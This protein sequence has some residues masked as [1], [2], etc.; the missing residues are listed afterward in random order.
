MS[1]PAPQQ[2]DHTAFAEE[3]AVTAVYRWSLHFTTQIGYR[4]LWMQDLALA[5]DNL[6]TN[7][8]ILTLGPAQLNHTSSTLYHGPYAGVV[9]AW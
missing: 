7:I 9:L 3:I 5:P 6:N 2:E 4:A 8:D 1:T